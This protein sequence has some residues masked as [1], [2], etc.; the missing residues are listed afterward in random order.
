MVLYHSNTFYSIIYIVLTRNYLQH[1]FMQD[2]GIKDILKKWCRVLWTRKR[3]CYEVKGSCTVTLEHFCGYCNPRDNL[4][5]MD[6]S[7]QLRFRTYLF[8]LL[9]TVY[10]FFSLF[11]KALTSILNCKCEA[12][13]M[14]RMLKMQVSVLVHKCAVYFVFINQLAF[15]SLFLDNCNQFKKHQRFG[16]RQTN[17]NVYCNIWL[18]YQKINTVS[19]PFFPTN[20]Q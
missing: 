18:I 9:S 19:L 4:V 12:L 13:Y 5:V 15:I 11:H 1:V 7:E 10:F 2:L 8:I 20:S 6:R 14:Y 16:R 3:K 17:C